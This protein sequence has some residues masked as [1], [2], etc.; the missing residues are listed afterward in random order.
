[1]SEAIKRCPFCDEEIRANAIKCKHCGSFLTDSAGVTAFSNTAIRQAL[2]A[3]F[4][5]IEEIGRGGMG[6]VYKAIQK[7]LNRPV[8]LKV[9]PQHLIHQEEFLKRFHGEAQKA[10]QLNHPNIVIVYDEGE[11]HGVHFIAMEYIDGQNLKDIVVTS[12]PL[13]IATMLRWTKPMVDALG[14]A[15]KKGMIHRDIKSANILISKEGRPVLT[16]F[17]IARIAEDSQITRSAEA[18]QLTRPGTILGTLQYMSPEQVQGKTVDGR[19]DIYSLGV[20]MYQCL[21]GEL[22]FRSDTDWSAMHKIAAELPTPPRGL[23]TDIPKAVEAIVLRCMAKNPLDRYQNCDELLAALEEVEAETPTTVRPIIETPTRELEKTLIAEPSVEQPAGIKTKL[24]HLDWKK[25]AIGIASLAV[26]GIV[27]LIVLT[28]SGGRKMGPGWNGLPEA[29]KK[30]VERLLQIADTLYQNNKLIDPP[31]NNAWEKYR[32]VLAIHKNNQ[33]AHE[34]LDLIRDDLLRQAGALQERGDY[35]AAKNLMQQGLECFPADS[36][37]QRAARHIDVLMLEQRAKGYASEQQYIS[38]PSRNA[39]EVCQK[40]LALDQQNTTAQE[41]LQSIESWF[42][43]E[44]E[45]LASAG[46]QILAA[47]KYRQALQFFPKNSEFAKRREEIA[48]EQQ[49]KDALAEADKSLRQKD[50]RRAWN[51]SVE[52][53]NIFPEEQS[54]L[55]LQNRIINGLLSEADNLSQRGN[56]EQAMECYS[57][58]KQFDSKQSTTSGEAM[59]SERWGDAL[60]GKRLYLE[61]IK[62]YQAAN[63]ADKVKKAETERSKWLEIDLVFVPGGAFEMGDTFGDGEGDEKPVHRVQLNDFSLSKCEITFNQYNAFCLATGKEKPSDNGWGRGT[64]PVIN[65][66]WIDAKAFCVWL[67][68]RTG[69]KVRLPTEAE[70]EYA[71]L[72]GGKKMKWAGTNSEGDLDQY[73]W[74]LLNSKNKTQPV[75]QQKPNGLGLFDMSGNAGE[76]CLDGYDEKFYKNSLPTNPLAPYRGKKVVRRGGSAGDAKT[77]LRCASRSFSEPNPNKWDFPTGFRIACSQ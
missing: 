22:P 5:I 9:L 19:S 53:K 14:Y 10:A 64:R 3:R 50:W 56:Y 44:G 25:A 29:D 57:L 59:L 38:P 48:G 61:A 35:V 49:L 42:L 4:E 23:R 75:G 24:G 72:A 21:T 17:G 33:F 40:I 51:K 71:A 68:Q 67:A 65:V 30:R 34:Q 47:E 13:P 15:H 2:M 18:S 12:G 36:A 32:K 8:A 11:E 55:E 58:V 6:V 52:L 60:F 45:K 28:L 70:W 26:L 41:I 20:V 46:Q 73:A 66:S 62:K 74:H 76:W 43:Q 63:K 39:Y 54:V 37:L 16:D 69:A 1:M 7:N 27:V 31:G 77:N